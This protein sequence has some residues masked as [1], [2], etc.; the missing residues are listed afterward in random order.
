MSLSIPTLHLSFSKT[1]SSQ[2]PLFFPKPFSLTLPPKTTII[3]RMGGGPRTFPGGVSKWQWKR[4]QKN[5]AK[6]LLKARLCRERQIYEMRKRAE[7]KAA[8]SELERPWEVVDKAPKLFSVGADEQ[9]KV[10]ADRFQKPGGFDLWSERDGPQLFETPDGVPSARFF[11][12]GVVQTVKPYGKVSASG[13]GELS[14]RMLDSDFG[15]YT[16]SE[17]QND[18]MPVNEKFSNLLEIEDGS[19]SESG[20]RGSS[21]GK[22]GMDKRNA[23]RNTGKY[24]KK[25][26]RRR[27]GNVSNAF[28]SGQVGFEKEKRVGGTTNRSAGRDNRISRSNNGSRINRNRRDSKSDVYDISLQQDGSYG[29][30]VENEKFN[31]SSWDVEAFEF[32]SF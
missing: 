21:D 28:D 32:D 31:S 19:V 23:K 6:Q 4:M 17:Y 30:Q 3:I 10:L 11:P 29:F 25:G 14:A 26:D 13:F 1:L 16:E 24:R 27:F 12:T 7:L 20:Y 15:S 22:L 18:G 2:N 9:V 5:K 8:V